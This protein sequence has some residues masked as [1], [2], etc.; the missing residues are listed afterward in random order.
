MFL[1]KYRYLCSNICTASQQLHFLKLN[2]L[3]TRYFA[4]YFSD[5]RV[6]WPSFLNLL[7]F[8]SIGLFFIQKETLWNVIS[9]PIIHS[10]IWFER[11][12]LIRELYC[13]YIFAYLPVSKLEFSETS[14]YLFLL[15]YLDSDT[16]VV[17][18][19]N[20]GFYTHDSLLIYLY[21]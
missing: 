8:P 2:L 19:V 4:C 11:L 16:K 21:Y 12:G 3:V 15:S 1:F 14:I 18:L 20:L 10:S 13:I 6:D 17:E 5:Y 9:L 7:N